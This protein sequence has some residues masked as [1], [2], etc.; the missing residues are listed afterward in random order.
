[1][2]LTQNISREVTD[3]KGACYVDDSKDGEKGSDGYKEVSG[4]GNDPIYENDPIDEQE[5][6]I[7]EMRSV[8]KGFIL[9]EL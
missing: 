3:P 5:T 4:D 8:G 1:M 7:N 9:T 2:A 6:N